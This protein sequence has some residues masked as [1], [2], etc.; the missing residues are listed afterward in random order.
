MNFLYNDIVTIYQNY[1]L[2]VFFNS[3]LFQ[4]A[5][6]IWFS[7]FPFYLRKGFHRLLRLRYQHR[8]W[9]LVCNPV[10][11]FGNRSCF[12]ETID[13]AVVI[14]VGSPGM[15][16]ISYFADILIG[17]HPQFPT[18]HGAHFG[19]IYKQDLVV[20]LAVSAIFPI[21]VFAEDKQAS[22]YPGG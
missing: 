4:I 2:S 17:E 15:I 10:L 14:A 21:A 22:W 12:A 13:V 5:P 18:G 9:A 11:N 19:S 8:Y 3:S 20:P 16:G 7:G 1:P 6:A